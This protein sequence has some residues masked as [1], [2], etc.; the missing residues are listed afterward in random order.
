MT[1]RVLLIFILYS[2]SSGPFPD[3]VFCTDDRILI[4]YKDQYLS[5]LMTFLYIP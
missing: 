5:W 4:F 3:T 1:F 2:L